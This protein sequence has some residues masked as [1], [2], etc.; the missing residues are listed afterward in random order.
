[1][2][3]F[4]SQNGTLSLS[5]KKV[6][7]QDPVLGYWFNLLIFEKVPQGRH[8]A[9]VKDR[10]TRL[11]PEMTKTTRT[12]LYG[13]NQAKN[14]RVQGCREKRLPFAQKW[15]KG[16]PETDT[17]IL[18]NDSWFRWRWQ[19]TTPLNVKKCWTKT[20]QNLS[21]ETAVKV[22]WF[23]DTLKCWQMLTFE[24]LKRLQGDNEPFPQKLS[25]T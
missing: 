9:G 12:F 4:P 7:N 18:N 3:N 10:K 21:F 8:F 14:D 1:M 24:N 22:P 19:N 16:V 15:V 20:W 5:H 13:P 11:L 25:K 23:G 17:P 6:R 2:N